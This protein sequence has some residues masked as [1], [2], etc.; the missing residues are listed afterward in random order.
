M[1]RFLLLL[2]ALCFLLATHCPLL[3]AQTPNLVL[4]A[5]TTG[6]AST[7]T[8][9][10][11]SA[12]AWKRF[13]VTG[14]SAG[15]YTVISAEHGSGDDGG[16]YYY[17][18]VVSAGTANPGPN[19]PPGPSPSDLPIGTLT[20]ACSAAVAGV[21]ANLTGKM[22]VTY[23]GLARSIDN[24]LIVSP[25]QLQLATGTQLLASFDADQ[26]STM[27]KL[28]AVISGWLDAQQCA[29]KLTAD[30]IG[31]YATAYHAI[32]QAIRPGVPAA[33]KPPELPAKPAIPNMSPCANGRCP[34]PAR[35]R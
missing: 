26:L 28:T 1:K 34:L 35:R 10:S 15:T 7:L 9:G 24:G 17:T 25:L 33:N 20:V 32:A 30:G 6:Q 5:G 4:S 12:R 29:G 11:D 8:I 14:G 31:K 3:P 21:D 23:E 22:A 19:P 16:I 18:V 2:F 27:Q 13:A